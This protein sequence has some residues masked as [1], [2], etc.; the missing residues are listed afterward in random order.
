MIRRHVIQVRYQVWVS[1]WRPQCTCGWTGSYWP[2]KRNAEVE[3]EAH[4]EETAWD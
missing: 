2:D 4:E 3:A 1:E